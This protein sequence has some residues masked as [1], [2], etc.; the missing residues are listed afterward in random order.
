MVSDII[1]LATWFFSKNI[2]LCKS[3]TTLSPNLLNSNCNFIA[4]LEDDIS[5]KDLYTRKY[6][7]G[8]SSDYLHQIE[9]A[10]LPK[11]CWNCQ[12]CPHCPHLLP[13]HPLHFVVLW[14]SNYHYCITSFNKVWTQVLRRFKYCLQHVGDSQWWEFLTIVPAGNKAKHPWMVDHTTQT[15]HFHHHHPLQNFFK[16]SAVY[17]INS[18]ECGGRPPTTRKQNFFKILMICPIGVEET[19]FAFLLLRT[20]V[21]M[22]IFCNFDFCSSSLML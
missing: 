3:H 11:K 5:S 14:C 20:V 9:C 19:L 13:P 10:S 17:Q 4:C 7:Q 21:F 2:L 6:F 16:I 1:N 8:M 18:N 22:F 15:I 12:T